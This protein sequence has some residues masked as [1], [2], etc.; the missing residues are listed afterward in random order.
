MKYG[1][2]LRIEF[3]IPGAATVAAAFWLLVVLG[4]AWGWSQHLRLARAVAASNSSSVHA[5]LVLLVLLGLAYTIGI[6]VVMATFYWPTNRLVQNLRAQRLEMLGAVQV[7]S[8]ADGDQPLIGHLHRLFQDEP[9]ER[10]PESLALRSWWRSR[11]RWWHQL[12]AKPVSTRY[13]LHLAVSLARSKMSAASQAEYEY[14]RS[15]RQMCIGIVPATV[16]CVIAAEVSIC[17]S[18]T[19]TISLKAMAAAL[20]LA[21]GTAVA[22]G[23]LA[24]VQYQEGVAQ[25]LLIDIAFLEY[26]AACSTAERKCPRCKFDKDASEREGRFRLMCRRRRNPG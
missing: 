16:I 15:V 13:D 23:L 25:W 6:V 8:Q 21:L 18:D 9:W 10:R 7:E 26:W 24:A 20:V 19:F 22:S 3:L 11:R 2:S 5:I 17:R 14:R 1:A 12:F 4:D